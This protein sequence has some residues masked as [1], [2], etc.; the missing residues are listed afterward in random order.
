MAGEVI[1]NDVEIFR[2][3]F[4]ERCL[5][6]NLYGSSECSVASVSFINHTSALDR[7]RISIGYPVERTEL[8]LLDDQ[9]NVAEVRGEIALGCDHLAL[10]YLNRD[11]LTHTKFSRGGTLTEAARLY[12]TGDLGRRRLD[13][14]ID[15]CGRKDFQVK[16]RGFRI[17]PAEI[18]AALG[19][20]E[21]VESALVVTHA[22][23]DGEKTSPH[24]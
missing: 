5:C 14:G 20:H 9:G 23:D 22:R 6:V 12:R 21:F 16:I 10:G 2:R 19:E 15:F 17:E 8:I 11:E 4:S 1:A 13:G 18:Q 3:H 24:L 7:H